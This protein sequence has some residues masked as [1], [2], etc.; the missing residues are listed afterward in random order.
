M[1]LVQ[2]D[3]CCSLKLYNGVCVR[4]QSHD[5]YPTCWTM[6]SSFV[7]LIHFLPF[8]SVFLSRG[9]HLQL[10]NPRRSAA[11]LSPSL[12]SISRPH[13]RLTD[14]GV[15]SISVI[16]SLSLANKCSNRSQPSGRITSRAFIWA[17]FALSGLPI[18]AC[19]VLSGQEQ[20][21]YSF[22]PS[23]PGILNGT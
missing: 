21:L 23:L 13:L 15:C 8:G 4:N 2:P 17:H 5:C 10:L 12:L 11:G 9:C 14:H 19:L 7:C 3:C 6:Y 20:C 16:N 18:R 22:H 1:V